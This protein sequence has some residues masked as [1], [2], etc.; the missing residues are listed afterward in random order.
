[1][2]RKNRNGGMERWNKRG[3]GVRGCVFNSSRGNVDMWLCE[4]VICGYIVCDMWFVFCD[5]WCVVY[6]VGMITYMCHLP[7]RK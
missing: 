1:M 7:C 6:Y 2:I 4:Y 5:M 3:M